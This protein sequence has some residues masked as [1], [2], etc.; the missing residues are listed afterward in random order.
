[1]KHAIITRLKYFDVEE[2]KHRIELTNRTIVPSLKAQ[3]QKA[4]I[5]ILI[6]NK[7]HKD[8][9]KQNI[10]YPYLPVYSSE[11]AYKYVVDNN[12]QIQSSLDSDDMVSDW[13][14]RLIQERVAENLECKA[15]IIHFKVIKYYINENR[16]ERR[17][18]NYH[19]QLVSMFYS[20]YQPN[21]SISLFA[22][23]HNEMSKH[24]DRVITMPIGDAYWIHHDTNIHKLKNY[25]EKKVIYEK[26]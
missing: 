9:I 21:P 8:L 11:E 12:I 16:F 3:N 14:V 7:E 13:Y 26:I 2:I 23:P 15:L 19:N 18:K 1:M 22:K 10:D 20:I 5:W 4:F 24:A 6:I 25:K 17:R